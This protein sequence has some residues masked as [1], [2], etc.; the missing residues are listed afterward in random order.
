[1]NTHELAKVLQERKPAEIHLF[2]GFTPESEEDTDQKILLL[3]F[4]IE[5]NDDMSK[6]LIV[7]DLPQV[8]DED[9]EDLEAAVKRQGQWTINEEVVESI[10]SEFELG[11]IRDLKE[12]WNKEP[13]AQRPPF[14]AILKDVIVTEE[15]LKEINE[16]TGQRNDRKFWSYVLEAYTLNV[17]ERKD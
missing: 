6:A 14:A 1:M 17:L 9:V 4:R 8:G 13:E 11:R 3:P 16:T 10:F 5:Y 7:P 12:Q 15:K 2:G